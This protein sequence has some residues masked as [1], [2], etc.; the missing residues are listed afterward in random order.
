MDEE[1]IHLGYLFNKDNRD[2]MRIIN[3]N[4][5]SL[6]Q[7]CHFQLNSIGHSSKN[8]NARKATVL[9]SESGRVLRSR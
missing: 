1:Y 8:E 7:K 6:S 5:V 4:S 9:T 3:K 2:S